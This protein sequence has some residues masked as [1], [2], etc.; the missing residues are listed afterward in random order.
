MREERNGEE[1]FSQEKKEIIREKRKRKK[2][3]LKIKN[4]SGMNKIRFRKE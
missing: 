4:F 1:G 3:S 2:S